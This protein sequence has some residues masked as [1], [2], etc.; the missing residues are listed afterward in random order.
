[1]CHHLHLFTRVFPHLTGVQVHTCQ[2]GPTQLSLAVSSA[3]SCACCPVCHHWSWR[4][5]SRFLRTFA[6]LP[7]A[8]RG[9][10]LR[11]CGRRFFCGNRSCSRRTF[12]E[13]VPQIAPAHQRHTTA[14]H[15]ALE[16]LGFALG[17]R[18]AERLA[19]AQ[20][21]AHRGSSRM[22]FLRAVRAAIVPTA[23]APRQIGVDDWAWSKGK[24]YGTLIVDLQTHSPVDL[25]ADRT[26]DTF[27]TWLKEHSGVEVISRDRSGAYAEGAQLGAPQALQ[28]ADRFHLVVRRI[29]ACLIP[30]GERRG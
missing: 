9:V 24:T 10:V 4:I 11:F 25:L 8:G 17:G 5:H 30:F 13:Q 7:S 27:A 28:V 26:A 6:D 12:R 14:F 20:G 21:F 16:R 2:V 3:A 19:Q 22:S 1:M 15:R 23:P 29:G 18:P